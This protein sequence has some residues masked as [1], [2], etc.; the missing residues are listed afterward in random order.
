LCIGLSRVRLENLFK[1]MVIMTK[2][3]LEFQETRKFEML[4][5]RRCCNGQKPCHIS[6]F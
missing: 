5:R 3:T 1:L 4:E 6:G 2:D